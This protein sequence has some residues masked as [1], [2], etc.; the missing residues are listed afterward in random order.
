MNEKKKNDDE[1][2]GFPT[3]QRPLVYLQTPQRALQEQFS[4]KLAAT[5]LLVSRVEGSGSVPIDF[6]FLRL[7]SVQSQT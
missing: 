3:P 2:L 4:L 6:V 5:S 7:G 1:L